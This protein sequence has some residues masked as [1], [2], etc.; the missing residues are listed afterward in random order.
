LEEI[1]TSAKPQIKMKVNCSYNYSPWYS[2]VRHDAYCRKATYH[3]YHEVW[4]V[5]A[6]VVKSEL[7]EREAQQLLIRRLSPESSDTSSFVC[8]GE[9][10]GRA[11]PRAASF[12]SLPKVK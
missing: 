11:L 8:R 10:A 3:K 6:G 12:D 5:N 4:L 1:P 2:E 7:Y 9:K